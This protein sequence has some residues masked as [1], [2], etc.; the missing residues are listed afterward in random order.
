MSSTSYY[1]ITISETCNQRRRR[2]LNDNSEHSTLW[3]LFPPL[4]LCTF[5]KAFFC[6]C[7]LRLTNV[8]YCSLNVL[9][10]DSSLRMII[11]VFLSP[12]HLLWFKSSEKHRSKTQACATVCTDWTLA[13]LLLFC[14]L[15][16]SSGNSNFYKPQRT[17][18]TDISFL[19]L[20]FS[21]Q[22]MKHKFF[23]LTLRDKSMGGERDASQILRA[24]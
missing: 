18:L 8:S 7:N 4:L 12:S 23:S 3:W 6:L 24:L 21:L 14:F 10:A 20:F 13:L 16:S 5:S 1:T 15:F 22:S 19:L 17:A 11:S 2:H 9:V